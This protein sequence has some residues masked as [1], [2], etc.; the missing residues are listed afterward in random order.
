MECKNQNNNNTR[1]YTAG[2]L[3]NDRVEIHLFSV[4]S[5][6]FFFIFENTLITIFSSILLESNGYAAVWQ[7]GTHCV[8]L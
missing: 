8:Y 1:R 6:P 5:M 4:F 2:T 7:Y 3:Y